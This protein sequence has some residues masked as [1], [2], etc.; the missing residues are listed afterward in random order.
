MPLEG[1][2]IQLKFTGLCI[3]GT[4]LFHWW[5][6]VISASSGRMRFLA[7]GAD[8]HI[9]TWPEAA[10]VPIMGVEELADLWLEP[11]IMV[12]K[13][14]RDTLVHSYTLRSDGTCLGSSGIMEV[15]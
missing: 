14:K 5:W 4:L 7:V 11:S 3:I 13:W 8:V 2:S 15:L 9:A 12:W 1:A 10:L 6:P